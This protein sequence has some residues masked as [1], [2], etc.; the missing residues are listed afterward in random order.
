MSN[1][2]QPRMPTGARRHTEPTGGQYT[3]KTVPAVGESGVGFGDATTGPVN[4]WTT[5]K[6]KLWNTQTTFTR[7]VDEDGV[8]S[9]TCDCDD[10]AF[11]V[12][13]RKRDVSYWNGDEWV[14][15]IPDRRLWTA[16]ITRQMLE[17]GFVAT[18]CDTG[19]DGI[20][21]A[22]S[23]ASSP[24]SRRVT[25]RGDAH[26]PNTLTAVVAQLRGLRLIESMA[27]SDG[28]VTN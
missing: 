20:H 19:S 24:R 10:L 17:E 2:T 27:P 18:G 9:V 6:V 26:S 25:T 11:W 8:V 28:W 14:K 3:S 12:L 13:A 23:A 21:A 22:M 7:T 5:R 15:N 1:T 16:D 4:N